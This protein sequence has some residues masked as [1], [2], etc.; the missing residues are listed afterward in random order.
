MKKNVATGDSQCAQSR[1]NGK[2]HASVLNEVSRKGSEVCDGR[3]S[4]GPQSIEEY[5]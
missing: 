5:I 1:S 3:G 2:H 4:I